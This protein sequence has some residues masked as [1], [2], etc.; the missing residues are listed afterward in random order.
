[1]EKSRPLNVGLP[2]SYIKGSSPNARFYWS[3]AVAI[4]RQGDFACCLFLMILFISKN[5]VL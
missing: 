1:M 2:L 3:G 4:L 5:G